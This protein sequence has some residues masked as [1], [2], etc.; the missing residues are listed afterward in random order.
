MQD[1]RILIVDDEPLVL[2]SL[3]RLLT[4]TGFKPFEANDIQSTQV[5]IK[6]HRPD[7]LLMDVFLKNE[8]SLP[9][10]R[11]LRKESATQ[12]LPII[13]ISAAA[14]SDERVLLL[15]SGA[16]DIVS[17]PFHTQELVA[18][19]DAVLRRCEQRPLI[20][21][22]THDHIFFDM[23]RKDVCV[24]EKYLNLTVKQF[25]LMEYLW[26]HQDHYVSYDDILAIVWKNTSISQKTLETHISNLRKKLVP[27]H[28]TINNRF[29][30]GYSISCE[31]M[32]ISV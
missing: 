2:K 21:D 25:Q 13:C 3:T 1:A 30:V 19:I 24:D 9:F 17:K 29:G 16:D 8:T 22:T 10:I 31:Y 4:K 12:R 28:I 6:N 23:N 15:R 14:D 7:L 18:R 26:S 32:E 27:Y 20:N 5:M 11:S